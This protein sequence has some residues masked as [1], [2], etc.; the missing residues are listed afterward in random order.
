VSRLSVLERRIRK[1]IDSDTQRQ[2]GH[3]ALMRHPAGI[4]RQGCASVEA[5]AEQTMF[6]SL[7][8]A[9]ESL[10]IDRA[11]LLKSEARP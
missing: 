4:R 5:G 11:E 10:G 7:I 9:A 8:P 3:A 1:Q 2:R 6:R